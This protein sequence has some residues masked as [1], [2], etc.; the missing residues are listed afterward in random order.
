MEILEKK[1]GIGVV[2]SKDPE[3]D[4]FD[5]V[6]DEERPQSCLINYNKN[7]KYA[8]YKL[9]DKFNKK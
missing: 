8:S 4:Y 9:P 7:L 1:F 6:Y 3:D 2:S 5:S